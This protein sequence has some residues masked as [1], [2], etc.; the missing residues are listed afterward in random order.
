MDKNWQARSRWSPAVHAVLAQPSPNESQPTGQAW[1]LLTS[2]R[3][4][5][6]QHATIIKI[7]H[8]AGV[9]G[10]V[11]SGYGVG[12]GLID[13]FEATARKQRAEA[14]GNNHIIGQQR[15]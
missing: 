12:I 8:L 4:R 13:V 3:E 7:I 2:V 1:R 5:H 6:G 10:W 14:G 9:P 11:I 15:P